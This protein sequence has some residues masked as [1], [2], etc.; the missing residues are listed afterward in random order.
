[1]VL[2]IGLVI[3][4]R[5][6][7][8]T[9]VMKTICG[10]NIAGIFN[11]GL[12]TVVISR[13]FSSTRCKEEIIWRNSRGISSIVRL[14]VVLLYQGYIAHESHWLR[15][16]L[17][18]RALVVATVS[19]V[20]SKMIITASTFSTFSAAPLLMQRQNL[21]LLLKACIWRHKRQERHPTARLF[22]LKWRAYICRR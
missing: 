19:S 16:R 20:A 5:Y 14:V 9:S 21:F 18:H 10:S 11:T 8:G 22:N 2:S 7:V 17:L 15:W 13:T 1:M 3:Q 4:F 6:L 12:I